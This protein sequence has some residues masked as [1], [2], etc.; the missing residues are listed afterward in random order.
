MKKTI[1]FLLLFIVHF[2]SFSQKVSIEPTIT[3]ELFKYN[4]QITVS[5][6]VTGTTLANLSVAY[7]WV[8][9]PQK[10]TNAKYNVNPATSA[11]DAAKFTKTVNGGSTVFS[12]TFRPSDFFTGD[13]STETQLGL[14]IKGTDW[15]NGQSTDFITDFWDGSFQ[16]RLTAPVQH[17]LFVQTND[18]VTVEAVA[19][20]IADFD[21]FVN[22]VLV[23]EQNALSDYTYT[24][25]VT[26]TSGGATI[27]IVAT[28]G[29]NSAEVSFQYVIP[30]NSPLLTR[31]AGIISG[32]NYSSDET[33]VT[34]CLLAPG[35]SS[36][37]VLGDFSDWNVTPEHLMNRDGE[38]FW[39]ELTGLTPNVEYGFQYLVDQTVFMADPFAD[40]VLDPDDQYIP[41]TTYPN[42]KPYPQKAYS[43]NWYFNRVAV[44]QTGQLPYAWQVTDFQKPDKKDL[45]IYELLI[46]DFLDSDHRNY[47]TLTDTVAYFKRLGVNAIE[48]MPIMEFNSNDSWGYNPTFLFAPD[49]YYGTKNDLKA[50]VDKCHQEGIAV[51]L[52]IAMNHHDMPN[53]YVIMDFD[54]ASGKPTANNKWFN[55]TA[56]HP[57]NVFFDMNHESTYTKKYLDTVNYYW[58]NEYKVDGF[59]FDLS[60]GFT[61]TNNPDDVSAWSAKDDSRIAIL[62][63]M[64]SKI[65]EHTPEAFIILEHLAENSEEKIL[66]DY[67]MLLWGNQN[68]TFSQNSMGFS[69]DSDISQTSYKTKN[70]NEP[71]LVS[72]M[73]SHD[74]ERMMFRNK[75][76]GNSF[77]TY[78]IKNIDT[79][80]DR[81]KAAATILFSIPGPKM[82]WQF[83]ELGYDI[84]IDENG[85][86]GAKPVKWD[87]FNDEHRHAL[88]EHFAKMIDLKIN[89]KIFETGDFTLAGGN[90]LTKQVTLKNEPY[91]ETPSSE[92]EM[93]VQVVAN[94]DVQPKAIAVDFPHTGWWYNQ[95]D[96]QAI[97]VSALP[98]TISLTPGGYKLYTDYSADAVTSVEHPRVANVN[99]FPNPV[100]K[101]LTISSAQ[102]I[103]HVQLLTINGQQV[104]IK[105]VDEETWDIAD[106]PSGLYIADI[107]TAN[108]S[109]KQKLI[110][111][112]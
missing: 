25:H 94:F 32:I 15:S 42:L 83:G 101:F 81:I 9:I 41:S 62:E 64:A 92:D 16:I 12:L 105:R 88:F 5:Y 38:Y 2:Y 85:R 45:V 14:L 29:G 27:R 46:R 65:W 103:L 67:G 50:F 58:L 79:G 52:D 111:H 40:K 11:I 37:Y 22:D 106:V 8:W 100:E 59:R 10:N 55:V 107:A 89:K 39:I 6:D 68:Y 112:K 84:S 19:P 54:F 61:Q 26:E 70:W 17:P 77:E 21:L 109:V 78:N 95:F 102:K 51:I 18:D 57:F 108:G 56:K 72:Y 47:Q 3:P 48:L 76:S 35:K 66:A 75:T 20:V 73:E 97:F 104:N 1:L 24:H 63:R 71:N 69:T 44:F 23:D 74:E 36:V 34:L 93:N 60:K 43:A 86:V 87:Y 110:K 4:D 82:F 30:A 80:L 91:T 98:K 99:V 33:K 90:S 13:I 7:L 53:P 49:K 31:P 28:S 96:G